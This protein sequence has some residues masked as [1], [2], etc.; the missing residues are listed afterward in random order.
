MSLGFLLIVVGLGYLLDPKAIL[1]LNATMREVFF[2][3][4]NVLLNGKRIGGVLIVLGFILLAMG[5]QTR[6]P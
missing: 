6:I 2:K 1:R 3:D 5:S 4:S